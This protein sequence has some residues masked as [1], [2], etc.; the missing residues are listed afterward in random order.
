M[1]A[2]GYLYRRTLVNRI[3]MA[4][5]RPI[6]YFYIVVILF[7]IVVM[8]FSIK[9]WTEQFSIDSPE[10]LTGVLTVFAFWLVP[11]NLIAFAKRKGRSEERRV[12]K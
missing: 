8:P 9:V 4:L 1:G 7:Y 12:G 2:I 5:R 10:G 11:G 3:K 6:T